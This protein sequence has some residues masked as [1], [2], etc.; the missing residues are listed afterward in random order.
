MEKIKSDFFV[1]ALMIQILISYNVRG[2]ENP[3]QEMSMH[4]AFLKTPT[5]LDL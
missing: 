3:Y 1:T 4:I 5:A 2:L